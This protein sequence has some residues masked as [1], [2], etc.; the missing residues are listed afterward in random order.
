M[1][2]ETYETA[3]ARPGVS[4]AKLP[5]ALI[6]LASLAL[7][8]V[9]YIQADRSFTMNAPSGTVTGTTFLGIEGNGWTWLGFAV[10]GL[11]LLLGSR[12]HIGAKLMAFIVG[13][14]Y[15]VGALIALSDGTDI[16]GIFATNKWTKL[17]LGVAGVALVALSM[18]PRIGRRR[19]VVAPADTVVEPAPGRRF[20]RTETVPAEREPVAT[21]T[22]TP[23]TT[24]GTLDDRI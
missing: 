13:V 2:A 15:G 20:R 23:G 11:L 10:G 8:V 1:A 14:A 6:G 12:F 21:T 3:P 18:L 4:L 17:A 16:L 9:G 19:A 7:G 24:N 22:T 5:V